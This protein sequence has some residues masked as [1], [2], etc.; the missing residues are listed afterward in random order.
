M[1]KKAFLLLIIFWIT[2]VFSVSA[3]SSDDIFLFYSK[4]DD[5][6]ESQT[7]NLVK[8]RLDEYRRF[9]GF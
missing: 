8:T 3:E 1:Y 2:G 9:A 4:I 7:K 6:Y 5:S